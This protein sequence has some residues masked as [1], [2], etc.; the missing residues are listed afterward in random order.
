MEKLHFS[1]TE[2]KSEHGAGAMAELSGLDTGKNNT[3]GNEMGSDGVFS[4]LSFSQWEQ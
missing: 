4:K 1:L 3:P 2:F